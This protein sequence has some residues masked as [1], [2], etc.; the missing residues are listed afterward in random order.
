MELKQ[1]VKSETDTKEEYE[2]KVSYT[3]FFWAFLWI[4]IL[5]PAFSTPIVI[6]YQ[7]FNHFSVIVNIKQEL[8]FQFF[9]PIPHI[10]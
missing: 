1:D 2:L 6:V 3:F 5:Y 9:T 4:K 8:A 10:V 7:P